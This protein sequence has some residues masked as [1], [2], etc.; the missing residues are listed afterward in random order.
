MT[1]IS[2]KSRTTA[3]IL[4]FLLGGIGVHRFYVG[5]VASGLLMLLLT[6]S[7]VGIFISFFWVWIDIIIISAG[8]FKDKNGELI[9]N[10]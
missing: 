8:G 3:L 1:L 6:I 7:V 2:N 4:A 9:S 5:K 10:W